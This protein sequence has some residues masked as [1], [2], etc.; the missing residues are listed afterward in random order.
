MKTLTE[1]SG[2]MIRMAA[3][4]ASEA[5]KSIPKE[6]LAVA[7]APPPSEP[8]I[9]AQPHDN[10]TRAAP[11][12]ERPDSPTDAGDEVAAAEAAAGEMAKAESEPPPKAEEAELETDAVKA[13]L[14]EA[15]SKAT[16]TSGDRLSRLREALQAVGRQAEK[17]RLVRVVA[18]D[19]E[20]PIPGAKKIGEFHYLVDLMPASMKQTFPGKE[21]KGGKRRGPP[22]PGMGPKGGKD[23]PTSLEGGFSMESLAQDRR[24]EKSALGVRGRGKPG[25]GG[26][27]GGPRGGRGGKPGGAPKP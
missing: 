18:P 23:A 2:T 11:D 16:G 7:P 12:A 21:E 20:E 13:I 10:A 22:R 8:E 1:F 26:G 9:T 17:V 15:V 25:G 24:A 4:A 14:D 3:K 19:G 5:R 27:R 6:V